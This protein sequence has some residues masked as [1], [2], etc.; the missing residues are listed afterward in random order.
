MSWPLPICNFEGMGISVGFDGVWAAA[1]QVERTSRLTT[2]NGVRIRM[3]MSNYIGRNDRWLS[4]TGICALLFGRRVDR[5][6]WREDE[7]FENAFRRFQAAT[8]RSRAGWLWMIK[9]E[10]FSSTICCFLK[11]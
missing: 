10:P 8:S 5:C 2:K 3:K 4:I 1:K 7:F 11:P 9:M 6:P